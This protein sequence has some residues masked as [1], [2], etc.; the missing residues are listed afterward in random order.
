MTADHGAQPPPPGQGPEGEGPQ[1]PPPQAPGPQAQPPY[2]P[3]YGAPYGLPN[4]PGAVPALVLG[5]VGIV[6][7][8]VCGPFAWAQA[9]KAEKAMQA[10]P[11]AYGGGSMVTAGKILGIIG[12]VLLAVGVLFF[13]VWATL[14]ILGIAGVIGTD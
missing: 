2:P 12:T 10:A 7:C 4:P 13:V 1:A 5:I 11:G 9:N 8:Q 3:P 6:A 14:A